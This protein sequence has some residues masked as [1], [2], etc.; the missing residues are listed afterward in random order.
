MFSDFSQFVV[1]TKGEKKKR[2][3][4]NYRDL[5]DKAIIRV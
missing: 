5:L 4:E 3:K 2:E 1:V